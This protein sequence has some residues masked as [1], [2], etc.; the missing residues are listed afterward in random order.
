MAVKNILLLKT[1]LSRTP[2]LI[3]NRISRRWIDVVRLK[4]SKSRSYDEAATDV[5]RDTPTAPHV[6]ARNWTS[7]KWHVSNNQYLPLSRGD[8][9]DSPATR[10]MSRSFSRGLPAYRSTP[11]ESQFYKKIAFS[12]LVH[13]CC[14][15]SSHTQN[16][17]WSN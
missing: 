7:D 15:F 17:H 4:S 16:L 11:A 1:C 9:Q 10:L 2:M 13:V 3:T 14:S 12:V 5:N 8:C 6:T